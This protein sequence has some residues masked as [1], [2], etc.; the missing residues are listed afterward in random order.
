VVKSQQFP[1]PVMLLFF[2]AREI[3]L[4]LQTRSSLFSLYP[5]PVIKNIPGA[6]VADLKGRLGKEQAKAGARW[7]NE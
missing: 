4:N 5:S 7:V 2:H 3:L 1:L 6:L